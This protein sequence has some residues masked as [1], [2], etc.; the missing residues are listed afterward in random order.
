M[1]LE[2]TVLK[3]EAPKKGFAGRELLVEGL[4]GVRYVGKLSGMA[5]GEISGSTV[6]ELMERLREKV[7]PIS[8]KDA[9]EL[10][11]RFSSDEGRTLDGKEISEVFK[12]IE[13]VLLTG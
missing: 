1:K 2:I 5:E 13:K 7:G 8:R 9:R 3:T 6:P 10:Q 12:G 4:L 11:F